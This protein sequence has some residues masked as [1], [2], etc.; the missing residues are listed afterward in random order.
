M[1]RPFD[2]NVRPLVNESA[3]NQDST[4]ELKYFGLHGMA[5]TCRLILATSGAKWEAVFPSDWANVEKKDTFFGVLPTLYETT[6][7][8]QVI[9]IPESGAIENYL[10][11]KFQLLGEDAWDE[12]K[13]R[14]FASSCQAVSTFYFLR[15]ATI[16]DQPEYKATML[17]RFLNEAVA[18]FVPVQEMHLNANQNNG[19][20]VGNKLSLADLR[21]SIAVHTIVSLT[22]DKFVSESKTPGIWAVYQKVNSIP[23][24]VEWR[25]TAAYKTIAEG[26]LRIVGV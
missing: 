11:Q 10:A 17:A 3:R 25:Q 9:E 16:R 4:F 21:L 23:S 24:Y 19:H 2:D 12:I 5:E 15:V 6:S 18:T 8:G 1:P 20:Y 22:E 13:I 26:N 14:A 7:S